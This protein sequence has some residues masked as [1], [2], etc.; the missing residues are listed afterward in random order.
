MEGEWSLQRWPVYL[1][2]FLVIFLFIK[3]CKGKGR[4]MPAKIEKVW[5]CYG[6]CHFNGTE[7]GHIT[8]VTSLMEGE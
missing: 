2:F 5:S 7:N 3:T 4:T 8:E 1:T 6:G